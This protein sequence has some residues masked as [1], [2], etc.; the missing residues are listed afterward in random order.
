MFPREPPEG[1]VDDTRAREA[2]RAGELAADGHLLRLWKPPVEPGEWPTLGLWS[3]DDESQPRA[4]LATMP[5]H[6]W[7]AVEMTPLVPH[8]SDPG[9]AA[10]QSHP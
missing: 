5:L 10:S 9:G 2:V 1:V 4:L 3:A 6:R 8:P 7:M